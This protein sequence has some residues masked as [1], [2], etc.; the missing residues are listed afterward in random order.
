MRGLLEEGLVKTELNQ[1][2][3]ELLKQFDEWK[4]NTKVLKDVKYR[5]EAVK[6]KL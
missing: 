2:T 1:E 4:P 5:L 6:S 3:A